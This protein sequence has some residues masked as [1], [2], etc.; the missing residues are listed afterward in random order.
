MICLRRKKTEAQRRAKEQ[1]VQKK[2]QN[3][4]QLFQLAQQELSKRQGDAY[5]PIE[6]KINDAVE[7]VAKANGWD[8]IF[9]S[10]TVGLIYRG[11]IDATT[12]VRKELGL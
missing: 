9:D 5:A 8:F 1:D 6:K 10:N 11:G 7:K 12:A 2:Q 3:L 4:Q